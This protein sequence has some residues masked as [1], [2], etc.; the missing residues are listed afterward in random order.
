MTDQPRTV[1]VIRNGKEQVAHE[2]QTHDNPHTGDFGNCPFCHEP[3]GDLPTDTHPY[4]GITVD[5][6]AG[7]ET[8]DAAC[9]Y[10]CLGEENDTQP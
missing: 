4:F 9:A 2:R 7:N 3:L 5:L 6:E 10:E 8:P 1:T